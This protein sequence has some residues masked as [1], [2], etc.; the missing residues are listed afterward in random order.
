MALLKTAWDHGGRGGARSYT[1][2]CYCCGFAH[3]L[4]SQGNIKEF[5]PC[6]SVYSVSSV[7]PP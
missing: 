2:N 5:S 4:P 6:L 1:E 3:D 7:V